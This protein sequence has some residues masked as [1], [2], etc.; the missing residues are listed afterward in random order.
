M[1]DYTFNEANIFF[2]YFDSY[3][4]SIRKLKNASSN[5]SPQARDAKYAI[6]LV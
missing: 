4:D 3:F 5:G 2:I 6:L 1:L